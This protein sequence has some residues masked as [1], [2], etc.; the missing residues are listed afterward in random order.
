ML[1][2]LGFKGLT[3]LIVLIFS[4]WCFDWEAERAQP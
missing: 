1:L 2:P 4:D 3:D